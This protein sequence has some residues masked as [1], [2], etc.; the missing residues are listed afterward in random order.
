[1]KKQAELK[2]KLT[3][4]FLYIQMS[5]QPEVVKAISIALDVVFYCFLLGMRRLGNALLVVVR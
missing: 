5:L 4:Y 1:M 2:L 3:Y